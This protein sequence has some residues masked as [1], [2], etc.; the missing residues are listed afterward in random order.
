[1]TAT[2]ETST[3]NN[4]RVWRIQ[5]THVHVLASSVKW[6]FLCSTSSCDVSFC[7]AYFMYPSFHCPFKYFYP[8]MSAVWRYAN[9]VYQIKLCRRTGL[10]S[11]LRMLWAY[12]RIVWD[13][14]TK[15]THF[16]EHISSS[17]IKRRRC[18]HFRTRIDYT[19]ETLGWSS[20]HVWNNLSTYTGLINV[21]WS[22]YFCCTISHEPGCR[23]CCNT[24]FSVKWR[25]Y[26]H[27]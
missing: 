27:R 8:R 20:N 14:S 16:V 10:L 26:K 9:T 11:P 23:G 6:Y 12:R 7:K 18:V 3:V 17:T 15:I 2:V 4:I 22:E 1:M 25:Y 5:F 19:F 13:T 21:H 24:S